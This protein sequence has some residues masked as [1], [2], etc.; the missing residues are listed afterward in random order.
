MSKNAVFKNPGLESASNLIREVAFK[1]TIVT[2]TAGDTG[3]VG[4][5][6][7]DGVRIFTEEG[8]GATS[9]AADA[10]DSGNGLTTLDD[11]GASGVIGIGIMCQDADYLISCS[12]DPD[13]CAVSGATTWSSPAVDFTWEGTGTT[14]VSA[15]YNIWLTASLT[16]L[17]LDAAIG[18]ASFVCVVKYKARRG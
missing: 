14:G 7:V 10:L 3:I 12:V 5:T 13:S 6:D 17:D 18:T 2:T 9:A 1:V 15:S 4:Y 11:D 16:N 8:T